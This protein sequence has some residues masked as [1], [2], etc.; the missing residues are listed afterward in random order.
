MKYRNLGSQGPLVS[1]L[2]L[3]CMGMSAS[4]GPT[5]DATSLKVIQRAY[6]RGITFFDTADMYGDG[7]NEQLLGQAILTFRDKIIIATKCGIK[8]VGNECQ[9]D[10]TSGYIKQACEASLKRLGI[11]AIDLYYLHRHYPGVPL[12]ESMGALLELV[13]EGKIKSVGLSEVDSE[14]LEKSHQILGN[15]LVA[16]QSEY[17]IINADSARNVL[18]TCRKLGI[19]FI[20]YSPLGRGLFSGKIRDAEDFKHTTALEYRLILPQFQP[21]ALAHNLSLVRAIEILAKRKDCTLAQLSLAWLLAQGDDIIPIPGTKRIEHLE[22]NIASLNVS[23]SEE[24]L[25]FI[26]KARSEN[27]IKG[28]RYPEELMKLFHLQM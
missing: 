7:A 11:E 21:E 19:S 3:G 16:L 20:P 28:R 23:L 25:Q 17:S 2:G 27:P 22:E 9:I 26:E 14:T 18:P 12:H 1:A 4:Y 15:H 8:F 10:N 24:D 5:N 13:K 6:D